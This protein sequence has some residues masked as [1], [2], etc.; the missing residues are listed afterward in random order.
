MLQAGF[1]RGLL[2]DRDLT[3]HSPTGSSSIKLA[4]IEGTYPDWQN[5]IKDQKQTEP[6]EVALNPKL[7]ESIGKAAHIFRGKTDVPL[8]FIPGQSAMKPV[9]FEMDVI[10]QGNF[11]ALLMPVRIP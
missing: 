7:V 3:V 11:F 8:R 6:F 5:L 10:D 2:D 4:V 1:R 9:Y